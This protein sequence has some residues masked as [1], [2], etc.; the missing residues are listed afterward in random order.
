M[1]LLTPGGRMIDF[2]LS[3]NASTIC[4]IQGP[5]AAH[6]YS[7]T[8]AAMAVGAAAAMVA[9]AWLTGSSGGTLFSDYPIVSDRHSH[10]NIL[11][12]LNDQV[13][14]NP[15]W[16]LSV[17]DPCKMYMSDDVCWAHLTWFNLID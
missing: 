3:M 10:N 17:D 1:P 11:S 5:L 2:Q 12:G 4:A 16:T 8:A 15:I 6:D 13:S 9:T 7:S 14:L